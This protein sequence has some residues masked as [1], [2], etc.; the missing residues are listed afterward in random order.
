MND[1]H[2][3]DFIRYVH[4]PYDRPDKYSLATPRC[5]FDH[6]RVYRI[7]T[8]DSLQEPMKDLTRT[9]TTTTT[10]KTTKVLLL[11]LFY[12]G[13]EAEMDRY[14]RFLNNVLLKDSSGAP[15]LIVVLEQFT[16]ELQ[17]ELDFLNKHQKCAYKIFFPGE[18]DYTEVMVDSGT[19]T[20]NGKWSIY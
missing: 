14:L 7:V 4:K 8:C 10:E 20:K 15:K 6:T 1:V 11:T 5:P 9:L 3:I 17:K 19:K 13:A 16:H 12:V 18:M 2:A